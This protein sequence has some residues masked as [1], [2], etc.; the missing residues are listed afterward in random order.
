MLRCNTAQFGKDGEKA[1]EFSRRVAAARQPCR[2]HIWGVGFENDGV[3]GQGGREL[4]DARRTG[5][6]QGAAEAELAAQP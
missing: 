4:S 2:R 3:F 6:A 1:G 5:L